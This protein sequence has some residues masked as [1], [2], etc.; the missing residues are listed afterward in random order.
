MSPRTR[1]AVSGRAIHSEAGLP[2]GPLSISCS[3]T[4]MTSPVSI[5]CTGNPPRI[6]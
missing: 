6:G 5:A 3:K 1:P 4:C 2:S